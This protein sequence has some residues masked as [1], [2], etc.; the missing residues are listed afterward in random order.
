M[1]AFALHELAGDEGHGDELWNIH[2]IK[3][4]YL[5]L[6]VLRLQIDPNLQV[7]VTPVF[8]ANDAGTASLPTPS[9][10]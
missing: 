10:P 2:E 3:K 1:V 4:K 8:L 9:V 7:I 6:E 5:H